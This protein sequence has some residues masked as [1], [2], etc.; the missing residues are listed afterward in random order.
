MAYICLLSYCLTQNCT[1]KYNREG[2]SV[3]R[4]TIYYSI[5]S[6]KVLNLVMFIVTDFVR[7]AKSKVNSLVT[8]RTVSLE[9]L[10]EAVVK[11]GFPLNASD[12]DQGKWYYLTAK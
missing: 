12:S 5:F 4:S 8:R 9:D 3:R 11:V 1:K 7:N 10:H 6:N 2:S